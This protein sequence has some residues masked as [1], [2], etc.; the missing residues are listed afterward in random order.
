MDHL[1]RLELNVRGDRVGL[2][3]TDESQSK[4]LAFVFMDRERRYF[5]ATASSLD[6]GTPINRKRWRQVDNTANANP[7]R[8]DITIPQPKA[9]ALYYAV[10]GRV[11]QHNR[12]RQD[13]LMIEKKLKTHDWSQRVNLTILAMIFVD[14]YR[15]YAR[16]TA[17]LM[18]KLLLRDRRYS[19]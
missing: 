13:T 6:E 18:M 8:L 10:C 4:Y 7:E 2:I 17:V 16:M 12:D 5:I 9:A 15:I 3:A 1:A 14:T 19:T 11:D